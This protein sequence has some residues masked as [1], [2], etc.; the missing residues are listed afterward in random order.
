MSQSASIIE[1]LILEVD[2]YLTRFDMPGVAESRAGI[3]R[4]GTTVTREM[5]PQWL[6]SCAHLAQALA[7]IDDARLAEA[8]G[9]AAPVLRWITYDS[10]P[11]AEVGEA[12]AAG[13]AFASLIGQDAPVAAVDYDLGLFFIAP[14]TLYRDRHHA[15][16]ELYAPLTGPH[17]WRFEPGGPFTF[18]PAHDPVWNEPFQPHA[19]L[20]GNVPF[21][22]IFC[23]TSDV[24]QPAHIIQAPDWGDY[25]T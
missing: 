3:A 9:K 20:T 18:R 6:P 19:T 16:P 12:L 17:G 23:W 25:E 11:R 22:C 5:V 24:D 1:N 4:W 2:R 13:H 14:N 7:T 8:I 10:Y 21:L 15:A